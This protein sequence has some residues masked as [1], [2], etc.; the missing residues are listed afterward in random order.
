MPIQPQSI[1]FDWI[2]STHFHVVPHHLVEQEVMKD[3]SSNK[4][5]LAFLHL[6][7]LEPMIQHLPSLLQNAESSFEIFLNT[8]QISQKVTF[9][10]RDVR[11]RVQTNKCWPAQITIVTDQIHTLLQFNGTISIVIL[12]CGIGKQ[13]I[14]SDG[15]HII[16]VLDNVFVIATSKLWSIDCH[17]PAIKICETLTH[18]GWIPLFSLC[19]VMI[20]SQTI[21][22]FHMD[23][24]HG[25]NT[26]WQ[27]CGVVGPTY[28]LQPGDIPR[29]VN[30]LIFLSTRASTK[31]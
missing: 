18:K 12:P 28:P 25:T 19:M 27:P 16:N 22:P 1:V 10:G 21:C 31:M 20:T 14:K 8:L 26:T 2:S 11:S 3:T 29:N 24:I 4:Y 23:H 17:N 5:L 6:L 15:T 13:L 7:L 9:N 30:I